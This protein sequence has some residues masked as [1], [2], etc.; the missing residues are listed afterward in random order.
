MRDERQI[1]RDVDEGI[2]KFKQLEA[3]K[4]ELA[5]IEARLIQDSLD[6][7]DEH[8]LLADKRR[9]GRQFILQGTNANIPVVFTADK[10]IKSRLDDNVE[11]K[12]AKAIAGNLFSRFY[13]VKQTRIMLPKDGKAFRTLAATLLGK[14][15]G[16]QFVSAC[17]DRDREGIPKNDTKVEWKRGIGEFEMQRDD[18]MEAVA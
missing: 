3:L 1:L 14:V 18:A 12:R 8:Q 13:T 17:L 7:P 16:P 10:I 15:K 4:G 11:L 6:R 9:E 5:E 2:E